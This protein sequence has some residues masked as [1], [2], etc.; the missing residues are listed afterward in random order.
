MLFYSAIFP[1]D[2]KVEFTEIEEGFLLNED[3][4]YEEDAIKKRGQNNAYI[5]Q[6]KYRTV[7]NE[8][9]DYVQ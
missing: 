6:R 8:N 3:S 4:R 7:K 5:Y 2:L 9:G 1:K